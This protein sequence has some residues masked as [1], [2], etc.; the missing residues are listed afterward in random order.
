RL[1]TSDAFQRQLG[2]TFEG[3]LRLELHLAPPI[4]F[5]Q[6][7]TDFGGSRKITFGP[8]MFKVMKV[9]AR[10]KWMRGSWFDITR[11]NNDRIVE[12]RLLAEYE[13]LIDEL[14]VSL[15]AENHA[16]AV[17]LARLPERIRGFG[18][19]KANHIA[20]VEPE[21]ERLLAEFRSPAAVKLAA[22]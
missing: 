9:L 5:L 15:T 22:E 2:E 8:W 12:R 4:P 20:A 17:A 14:L 21:R 7:K 16:A 11:F 13:A 19:I 10:L 18:H 1:Y 6:R 3:D